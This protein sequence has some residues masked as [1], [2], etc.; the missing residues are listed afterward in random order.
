MLE[1]VTINTEQFFK[2]SLADLKAQMEQSY[3]PGA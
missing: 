1:N 2:K 3:K